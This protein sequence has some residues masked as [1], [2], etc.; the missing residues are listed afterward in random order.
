MSSGLVGEGLLCGC[1]M[2]GVVVLSLDPWHWCPEAAAPL[3]GL[4]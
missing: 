3:A 2:R 1:L 4:C